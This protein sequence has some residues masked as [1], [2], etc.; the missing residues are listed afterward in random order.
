M[1]RSE[2]QKLAVK[3]IDAIGSVFIKQKDSDQYAVCFIFNSKEYEIHQKIQTQKI[4]ESLSDRS[5]MGLTQL[6]DDCIKDNL[7][8][9]DTEDSDQQCTTDQKV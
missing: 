1:K 4:C 3:L 8:T 2:A 6:V 7:V 5:Q 9:R